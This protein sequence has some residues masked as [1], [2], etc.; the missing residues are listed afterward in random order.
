M[1]PTT[2]HH[3]PFGHLPVVYGRHPKTFLR[4]VTQGQ[5]NTFD[6]LGNLLF[7]RVRERLMNKSRL[8]G[9]NVRY[10]EKRLIAG[11][12]PHQQHVIEIVL[13]QSLLDGVS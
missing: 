10:A 12:E 1:I 5:M 6:V 2:E 8:F 9:G 7:N 13:G 4:A 11:N 3:H